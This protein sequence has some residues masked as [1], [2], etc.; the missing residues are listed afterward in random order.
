MGGETAISVYGLASR[1]AMFAFFPLIGI[2]QGFMPIA[3][4]NFGASQYQRV[5]QVI[6]ISLIYGF[7]VAA[8]ICAILTYSSTWIPY[9]FTSDIKLIKYSPTAIFWL[10]ITAPTVVFHLIGPS[11]YQAIGKALPAL[12]LTIT[13]QGLF[14]IPLVIILPRYYGICL[15]YTSPSPRDLSTS[16]MPSSA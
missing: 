6:N 2:A 5:K 10:F 1:L 8:F 11:Y 4:Y 13:K 16:R 15:L 3:G 7:I 12:L 9:I 14:L